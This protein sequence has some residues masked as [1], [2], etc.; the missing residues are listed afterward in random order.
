MERH[1]ALSTIRVARAAGCSAQ[2]VRDL[3]AAGVVPPAD[4]APNGYRRF[5]AVHVGAIRAYRLLAAAV[6]PS[7]ARDVMRGLVDDPADAALARIGALHVDLTQ[8]R[9]RTLFALDAV[10]AIR[11][12]TREDDADVDAMTITQ[13]ADALGVRPSTLRYWELEGLVR[14]ERRG[15][16]QAR[17]YPAGAIREA[18][19]V[20]ALR[21]SGRSIP[22][23]AQVMTD[24]RDHG[25]VDA[26]RTVLAAHLEDVARRTEQLLR[27]GTSLVELRSALAGR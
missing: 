18:R 1:A 21:T 23:T 15:R 25:G 2:L 8:E 10:G 3:E 26:L 17:S 13:L 12:E 9:E 11:G 5:T 16:L 20:S 19:I 27:A 22:A 7:T 24:L 6:G 14:P 4:R